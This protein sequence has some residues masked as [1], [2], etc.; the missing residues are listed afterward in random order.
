MTI[1]QINMGANIPTKI[2]QSFKKSSLKT[3]KA[4]HG[5]PLMNK[6]L[7]PKL[8]A[9][10]LKPRL[11]TIAV[12]NSHFWTDLALRQVSHEHFLPLRA[13]NFECNNLFNH[14]LTLLIPV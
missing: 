3:S 6:E 4:T 1:T 5:G 14:N 7:H 12:S 13:P 10:P 2:P 8:H 9:F 11:V